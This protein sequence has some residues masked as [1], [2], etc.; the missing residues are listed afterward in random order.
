MR[1]LKLVVSWFSLL[2]VTLYIPFAF[3][4]YFSPWYK[5]NCRLHLISQRIPTEKASIYIH[6]LTGFFLHSHQLETGW[7]A[8]E[9]FHLNEVRGIFDILAGAA[10]LSLALFGFTFNKKHTRKLAGINLLIIISLTLIIPF[11]RYFWISILHPLLFNNL[12]W[13]TNPMDVSFFLLPPA[14]FYY[15]TILLI[16]VSFIINLSLWLSFR[17]SK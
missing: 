10:I 5:L 11:F 17:D 13:R 12:A 15:S 4:V 3:M 14:F 7:S 16:T 1:I 2:Y 9:K 6:E 8:K